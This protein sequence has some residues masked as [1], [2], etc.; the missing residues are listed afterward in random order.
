MQYVLDNYATTAEAVD[1][2]RKEEF[3]IVPIKAPT[4]EPGTVHLSV[5]DASGDSAIFEY[6]DGKLTIHHGKQYQVMTNSPTYDQQLSLAAYWKQ[7]GGSTMLPGTNRAADRFARLSYYVNEAKQS[8]DPREA[9]ATVFSV[10]RNVSVPIGIKVPGSP[11]IADTLWL[12]VSDQKNRVYFYQS[13]NS[14]SIVWV[15]MSELDLNEGSGARK[16]QLDGN[17]DVAGDQTKGFKPAE[18]FKF[19]VP[20]D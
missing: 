8:A 19:I 20:H 3:R 18:V 15:K 10:M 6:I 4:G 9:V 13:T 16:L 12:T 17:P 11:N 2:L 7:I 14:P 1:G 5:S